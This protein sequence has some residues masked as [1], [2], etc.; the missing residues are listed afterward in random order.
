MDE[1]HLMNA[2][3]QITKVSAKDC[4][5]EGDLITFLVKEEEVGKAI[6]KKAV[7]VKALQDKLKKRVEIV[8]WQNEPD[9]IVSK[10]LGVE[11]SSAKVSGDKLIVSLDS[12]NRRK[13]MASGAKIKRIK[14][15][16]ERNFEK[17]LI[18]A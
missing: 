12:E 1:I 16:I 17:E 6:G 8:G 15:L 7:N 11:V 2:L 10:A 5:I 9:K 3:S 4:I 18:L 14:K 13:A